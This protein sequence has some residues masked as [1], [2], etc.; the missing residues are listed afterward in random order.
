MPGADH[1]VAVAQATHRAVT[2]GDEEALGRHRGVGQ[3]VDDGLLQR[4]AGQ[5][6]RCEFAHHGLHVAVHLGRLAQQHVHGHVHGQL[7]VVGRGSGVVQHQLALFR[8][9]ADHRKRAA[10]AFAEGF[11]QGQRLGRNRQHV[12][13][14]RL[15]APDFLRAHAGLF[16]LHG[17]QVKARAT[18]CVVGQLGEGVGQTAR[19]HV[20]DGQDGVVAALRPAVV[21]DLLRAALDL[22]V[23]ALH[24]VKVQLG[25]I[26]AGGHGAG[27]AAA[28]ADAHAGAAQLDEQRAS[29][30]F[31]FLRQLGIDHAHTARN[32]DGLVVTAL[33]AADF[34]LVFAEVAVQVG[35][36]KFVVERGAAQRAF[37]HDLQRAGNVL[38]LAH[39]ATPELGHGKA[40]E[41]RL[42][43]GA[44]PRGAFVANLAACTRGG[45][46]EGRDGRGVVVRFH[47]HQHMLR[48]ATFLIAARA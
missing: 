41:A 20:V 42:G 47:L 12:A 18:A 17:A 46:G 16:E 38:R 30:E 19:A 1:L 35:A 44:A 13:L 48:C 26:G 4:H 39:G 33:H 22:G 3:H 36:A 9:R 15:V 29:G 2:D 21:D 24:R 25:R 43:L 14:L 27:G 8:G 45:A 5:V 10:L 23:A 31:D 32:H 7:L 34:L 37:D 11:E 6:H 28:H 40:R